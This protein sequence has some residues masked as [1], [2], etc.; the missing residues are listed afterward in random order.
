MDAHHRDAFNRAYH[1]GVYRRMMSLLEQTLGAMPFRVA[2]TPVFLEA[3]LRD[4]VERAATAL[5][6]ELCAPSLNQALEGAIPDAWRVPGGEPQPTCV[7]LDFALAR[8]ADGSV[9]PRLVELQAFPSLYAYT[10]VQSRIWRQLLAE[11]PGIDPSLTSYFGGLDEAGY[12]ALLREVLVGDEDPQHVVL[13]DIDPPTQKTLPDFIGTQGLL[14]IEPL[15][16]SAL[17][18]EGRSLFRL[19]HGQ[20]VPV[21]RI[22]NRVVF[23]EFMQRRPAMSFS[24]TDALDVH[25]VPHPNWQWTWS[26][27]ALPHLRHASVP[28]A[29]TLDALPAVLDDLSPYVLKPLFSFAGAGVNV[30]PTPADLAAVPAA[31]RSR[32]LLQE[33]IEYARTLLTP[34][35]QGV[36]AEIRVLCLKGAGDA[37]PRPVANLTRLSRGKMLG[38]DFNRD[39]DWVGSTVSLWPR[40]DANS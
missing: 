13:L 20:R 28:R 40:R 6:T 10:C 26:K 32:W 17:Q 27:A 12:L 38:V 24:F 1:P 35:G 21:R 37:Q 11:V 5:L 22:Y 34:E 18:V 25:F 36:A 8:L 9:G 4:E 23:D 14:G 3:R 2:E 39:F 29:W 15:C 31:E 7:T 16:V 33:K 19:R 30:D